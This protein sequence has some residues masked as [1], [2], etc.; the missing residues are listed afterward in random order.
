M[1]DSV[2][3]KG[4]GLQRFAAVLIVR[5]VVPIEGVVVKVLNELRADILCATQNN[6]DACFSPANPRKLAWLD[7]SSPTLGPRACDCGVEATGHRR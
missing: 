2:D 7:A 3:V 1:V 6:N 5:V 4:E